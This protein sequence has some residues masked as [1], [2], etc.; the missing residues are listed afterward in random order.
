MSKKY[1]LGLST[2][3]LKDVQITECQECGNYRGSAVEKYNGRVPV[4]CACDLKREWEEHHKF[5]SPSMIC[6]HGETLWWT[7][8]SNYRDKKGWRHVPYFAG[9]AM[10]HKPKEK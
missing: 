1:K 8:I 6:P 7:P 10:N 9:P 3:K 4:L 5:P 2:K